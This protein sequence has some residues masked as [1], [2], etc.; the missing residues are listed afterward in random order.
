MQLSIPLEALSLL[1]SDDLLPGRV[2][3][4]MDLS[5]PAS[6]H[7]S[8]RIVSSIRAVDARTWDSLT[9]DAGLY[10]RRGLLEA[11]EWSTPPDTGHRYVVFSQD[12]EP[13]GVASVRLTRFHGPALDSLL[14]DRPGLGLLARAAGFEPGPVSVPVLV[15]GTRFGCGATGVHFSPEVEPREALAQLSQALRRIIADLPP[16]Q[17]PVGVLV[18]E[19]TESPL[20]LR[21]A[22]GAQGYTELSTSPRMVLELDPGW[23]SFEDYLGALRSKFRVKAKR[24]Y[25]KSSQLELRPLSAEDI[26]AERGRL[27]E[28][29]SG[30]VD[31]AGFR[32]GAG[33]AGALVPLRRALGPE[34]VVQGYLLDGVLV[35]FMTAFEQGGRLDAHCVGFDYGLNREHSIYPR[36]LYDYLR[37][38]LERGLSAVDYGRTAEEIKSTVGAVPVP[39]RAHLRHRSAL[40]NPLLGLVTANIQPGAQPL[41]QP[42]KGLPGSRRAA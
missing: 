34:F 35:G 15:C 6:C 4:L 1:R 16:S 40:F 41:R 21:S 20:T 22:L 23:R 36:M 13:T 9:A 30:V 31:R 38:A 33:C 39:T 8:A 2:H 14:P 28:L 5:C 12:G 32:M 24:A 18:E 25:A 11:V 10:A 26:A 3:T 37:I 42:F 29:Y 17:R 7:R 19:P 27:E